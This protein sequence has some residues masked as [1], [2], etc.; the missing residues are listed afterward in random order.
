[1]CWVGKWTWSPTTLGPSPGSQQSH[2]FPWVSDIP[3]Q[4][5]RSDRNELCRLLYTFGTIF[6]DSFHICIYTTSSHILTY[7]IKKC[8][9]DYFLCRPIYAYPYMINL[10]YYDTMVLITNNYFSH[11]ISEL[12]HLPWVYVHSSVCDTDLV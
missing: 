7:N 2:W 10:T 11:Q 6:C 8:Y 5:Q 1:M 9:M 3:G 4:G 12:V